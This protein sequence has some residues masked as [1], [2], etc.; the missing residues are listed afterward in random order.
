MR[1]EGETHMP[2][3]ITYDDITKLPL[4][5]VVNAANERLRPGG[6]VC[7]AIFR[8]AGAGL[9]RACEALGHCPT[10]EAVITPGFGLR[11][12]FVIHAVGPV[13]QGGGAGERE[14]LW[15]CYQAAMKLAS[16][17]GLPS[18][19]F[20]LIS[21]GIYGYPK[22]DAFHVAVA[23]IGDRLANDREIT[24][25][26]SNFASADLGLSSEGREKVG[27]FL[28]A[29]GPVPEGGPG[30]GGLE[31][32]KALVREGMAQGGLGPGDLAKRANLFA[33]DLDFI[34]GFS[35]KGPSPEKAKLLA[36]LVLL[37]AGPKGAATHLAAFGHKFDQGSVKDLVSLFFLENGVSDVFHLNEAIHAFSHRFLVDPGPDILAG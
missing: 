13:W 26:L 20:P 6:G 28:K 18:V 3:F 11:A 30:P 12:K 9:Q 31:G 23:S 25:F 34:L 16:E 22:D 10:G 29:K 32:F 14:R 36:L 21:S 27:A 8:G 2:L 1:K 24:V 35:G 17:H 15:S 19:A 7:G 5:A 4:G 33:A 37:K